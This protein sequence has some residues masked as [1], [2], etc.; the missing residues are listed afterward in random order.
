M[1]MDE[2]I[3]RCY[4]ILGLSPNAS[5]ADVKRAYRS[6]AKTWH[7]DRFADNLQRQQQAAEK[8]KQLNQAY[9]QIKLSAEGSAPE[10]S[11]ASN[12]GPDVS[13]QRL[14]PEVWYERGVEEAKNG[15]YLDAIE[16]L[17]QAIRAKPDYIKAYQYRGF[18]N[19][20]LGYEHQAN[21]DFQK[22]ARLKLQTGSSGSA[23]RSPTETSSGAA[24]YS[25]SSRVSQ[26]WACRRTLMGHG[27]AVA[28]IAIAPDN[29][30]LIS[31]SYDTNI[32][33]WQLNVGQA[34]VSLRGHTA[35]IHSLAISWEG[36]V[37]ASASADKT[38]RLWDL[39]KRKII[40]T[41]GGYFSGH[42][43][44]VLAVA[45]GRNR[46][47]LISGSADQTVRLWNWRKGREI[48]TLTGYA[49]PVSTLAIRPD[50][51][52]FISGDGPSRL[53]IRQTD[54]GALI[55]SL[56]TTTIV[57]S[58]GFNPGGRA[59]AVGGMDGTLELRE[60]D[61]GELMRSFTA[62]TDRISAIAFS[63]DRETLATSSWDR[64]IKIWQADSGQEIC[65][66]EEHKDLVLSLAFSSN[67]EMLVSGDA[68]GTIKVWQ[69]F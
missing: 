32:K 7:P 46:E 34:I 28:A 52:T 5:L 68:S 11:T 50:G 14:D 13:R 22:V 35:P 31:G 24:S 16:S 2:S 3:Q 43:E 60:A 12:A 6:L 33:L 55:Q 4:K 30:L 1:P 48:R 27:D 47:I 8:F 64:T 40:C 36:E 39:T 66:L 65:K 41:L 26:G 9:R 25:T 37:L 62:H 18:L 15:Q 49:A 69:P 38:I 61:T 67:G 58:L 21:A 53:R 54:D 10:T 56:K 29:N 23:D 63:P 45:I 17:T 44:A 57:S 51:E 59:I 19:E 42:S 20:K